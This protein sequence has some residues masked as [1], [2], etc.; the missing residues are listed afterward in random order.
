MKNGSQE[1][2]LK[3]EANDEDTNELNI[4]DGEDVANDDRE[5]QPENV[6]PATAKAKKAYIYQVKWLEL[7]QFCRTRT[8][9]IRLI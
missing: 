2:V 6:S 7:N 3:H 4:T 1:T 5:T 8:A 9:H